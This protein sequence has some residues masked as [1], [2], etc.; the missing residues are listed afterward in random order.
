MQPTRHRPSPHE[1]LHNKSL[2]A[3][4]TLHY[5]FAMLAEG[6]GEQMEVRLPEDLKRRVDAIAARLGMS[7]EDLVVEAVAQ[8]LA[9]FSDP[10]GIENDRRSSVPEQG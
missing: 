3:C 7:S 2:V 1:K 9:V 6:E 4:I 5:I 10:L 8:Q